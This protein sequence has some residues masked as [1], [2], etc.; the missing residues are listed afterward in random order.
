V[1]MP[2]T[3]QRKPEIPHMI[4]T[5]YIVGNARNKGVYT[6]EILILRFQNPRNLNLFIFVW[7]I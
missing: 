3:Q 6:L 1:K 7:F 5:E 2:S 4:N